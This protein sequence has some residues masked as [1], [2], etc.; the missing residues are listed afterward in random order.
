M[1]LIELSTKQKELLETEV[2]PLLTNDLSFNVELVNSILHINYRKIDICTI[3]KYTKEHLINQMCLSKYN[4]GHIHILNLNKTTMYTTINF[5]INLDHYKYG[6]DDED[7]FITLYNN[8]I[9][10]FRDLNTYIFNNVAIHLKDFQY[11]K[12]TNLLQMFVLI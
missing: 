4:Y 1:Q 11:N 8:G 2:K 6:K 3:V 9:I 5:N 12:N 10:T 7:Y